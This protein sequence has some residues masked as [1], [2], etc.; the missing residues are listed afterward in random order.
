MVRKRVSLLGISLL[1]VGMLAVYAVH[2][3][4]AGEGGPG[5]SGIVAAQVISPRQPAS[6]ETP[7]PKNTVL[8][9]VTIDPQ[10]EMDD[11]RV[12]RDYRGEAPAALREI[13]DWKFRP[14]MIEG[15]P[16]RSTIPVLVHVG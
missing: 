13:Q 10:G 14:A 5:P 15:K 8:L 9:E 1:S 7:I 2:G 11:V 3:L 16:I 12:L 4:Y 6:L